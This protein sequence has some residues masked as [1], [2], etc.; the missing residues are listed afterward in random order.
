MFDFNVKLMG[1]MNVT[2]VADN[3]EEAERILNDT[4]DSITVKDIREKLTH[5]E[6]V[7]IKSSNVSTEFRERIK[8]KEAER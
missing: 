2:V 1:N 4:I 8:D 7:E 3:K 5:R 6:N